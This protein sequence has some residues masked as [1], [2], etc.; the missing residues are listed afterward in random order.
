[1]PLTWAET[2]IPKGRALALDST[3]N[4]Y[5]TGFTSS[6]NFPP[7]SSIQ[8][9][10]GGGPFDAY[11][12]KLN[13]GGTAL[14]YAH[15]LPLGGI[16]DDEGHGIGVDSAGNAYVTGSTSSVNFPT[17]NPFQAF[18]GGTD[19]FVAELNPT[20]LALSY[21]SYLGGS[22][23]EAGNGIALD[24]GRRSVYP[25]G[26][27]QFPQFPAGEPFSGLLRRRDFRRVCL[28]NPKSHP[29]RNQQPYSHP[30]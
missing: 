14:A 23:N 7:P 2:T 4:A 15:P 9:V 27:H 24:S 12:A 3:G 28:E 26:H 16:N 1:M 20:G 25:H 8:A 11:V 30:H 22:G 17:L 21:S 5:I 29:H 6:T 18:G 19:A 10:F 13:P